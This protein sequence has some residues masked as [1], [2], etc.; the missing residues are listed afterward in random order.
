MKRYVAQLYVLVFQLL[1]D[2]MQWFNSPMKRFTG[3][4]DEQSLNKLVSG[5][6]DKMKSLEQ[7]LGNEAKLETEDNIKELVANHST[8][9]QALAIFQASIDKR[10]EDGLDNLGRIIQSTMRDT[11][12]SIGWQFQNKASGAEIETSRSTIDNGSN[13][14]QELT[15][16]TK[17]YTKAQLQASALH[18]DINQQRET[19]TRLKSQSQNMDVNVE[20]LRRMKLLLST[21][22]ILQSLWICGQFQVPI[23]SRATLTAANLSSVAQSAGISVLTY[24]CERS[25]TVGHSAISKAQ[26]TM[27]VKGVGHLVYSL[28][29]QLVDVLPTDIIETEEDLSVERFKLLDG[30]LERLPDAVLLLK[31]IL[32]SGPSLLFCCFDSLQLLKPNL[33]KIEGKALGDV[34][35]MFRNTKNA[36]RE[37]D[38]QVI[39]VLY[40]TD[41]FF[42]ALGRFRGQ[43]RLTLSDFD[44]HPNIGGRRV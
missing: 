1:V 30:S 12:K 13:K 9:E 14:P 11:A 21:S 38:D 17:T 24:F 44:Y 31:N 18:L 10:L 16:G 41:G 20:V 25:H 23:P 5:K 22:S 28:I 42:D 34:I 43:E 2:I 33:T 19:V 39:K 36:N 3:A 7:K 29:W 27:G 15:T 6:M 37:K 40:T 32:A 4:F 35:R 8:D 26:G